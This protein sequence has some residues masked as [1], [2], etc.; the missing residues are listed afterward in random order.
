MNDLEKSLKTELREAARRGPRLGDWRSALDE[1]AQP[2]RARTRSRW[3]VPLVA[4]ASVAVVAA[5][6]LLVSTVVDS[7]N[8]TTPAADRADSR[9]EAEVSV[10]DQECDVSAVPDL[11]SGNLS[12]KFL[13][14]VKQ[15][16]VAQPLPKG[17]DP[18]SRTR[19]DDWVRAQSSDAQAARGA[20]VMTVQVPYRVG[21]A[22]MGGGDNPLVA[23][24]R[25]VWVSVTDAPWEMR[26]HIRGYE[27]KTF[28]GYMM[29]HDSASGEY[30]GMVAGPDAIAKFNELTV[31]P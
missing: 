21:A 10:L 29:M 16:R 19:I 25:C 17:A 27:P 9:A 1:R 4:A 20:T 8:Q 15:N 5:G 31:T 30:L 18:Y 2:P 26:R 14:E 22:W 13:D 23:P 28:S 12:K 6:G 24:S 3:S 7:D 11:S